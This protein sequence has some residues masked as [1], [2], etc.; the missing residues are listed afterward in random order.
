[1]REIFLLDQGGPAGYRTLADL[2]ASTAPEPQVAIDPGTDLA[3]LPYSSGTTGLP[4]GVMLTH[5]SIA[6]NLAQID[7]VEPGVVG[8]RL[9]AVLPFFHIYGLV[10]LLHRPLQVGATVVVL[11]RFDLAQ[12]LRTIQD[13]RIEG[14]VVAPPIVLALAKHPLVDEFDLSSI[15]YVRSAAAPLDADLAAAC[16]DRLG[17][18]TVQQGY[19]MTE[20]SPA[21]HLVP[22][23]D[24]DPAP[25]R[26]ASW[27][28]PPSCGCARWTAAGRTSGPASR[29][30][31]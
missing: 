30:R 20:L 31:S 19:G 24:P 22:L 27:W 2:R 18:A 5:R 28:P 14:L 6:T 23:S 4:K 15:R 3:A 13:H 8:E 10:I 29:A 9:I 7:A 25:A 16:A 21:T 26:S 12:F 11:P 1:M 17:L